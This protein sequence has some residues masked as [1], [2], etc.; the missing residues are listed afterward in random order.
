MKALLYEI[1]K[2]SSRAIHHSLF[3]ACDY[4]SDEGLGRNVNNLTEDCAGYSHISQ[5][6]DS[7]VSYFVDSSA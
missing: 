1:G 3:F 2:P 6:A 4:H 5:S 7:A